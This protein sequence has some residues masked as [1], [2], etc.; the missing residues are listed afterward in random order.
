M[1]KIFQL[2]NCKCENK[3]VARGQASHSPPPLSSAPSDAPFCLHFLRVKR[4]QTVLTMEVFKEGV[5][6]VCK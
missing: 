6:T 4:F 3:I 1:S 5:L 2:N